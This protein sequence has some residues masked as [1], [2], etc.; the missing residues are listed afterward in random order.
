MTSAKQHWN[1]QKPDW[2]TFIW[3]AEKLKD[4]E[5]RFLQRAGLFQGALRHMGED[6]K[7][8]LTIEVIS[9]EAYKT[10]EIEG[11]FLDR[12]SLQSSL[13]RNFGLGGEDRR[14]PP[15][16]KGIAD[17]MTAL[18]RG[19]DRLLDGATLFHWHRLVMSARR[20]VTDVGCYRT[21]PDPMQVVSGAYGDTKV[22]FE[23]PPS[24]CMAAEMARFID[25]F[26]DT[27]PNNVHVLPPLT[28]A[29]IAHLWFV[30]IHPF[31][32]GNGRIGRAISEL[33]LSQALARPTL[34]ALAYAIE[35][36]RTAYY[37]ALE[38]SN[39]PLEITD[40]LLWFA[41]TVLA[42]QARSQNLIDFTI[43]KTKLLDRLRA[44]LNER[45]TKTL[46]RMFREG[47]DGFAGG[48]SAENYISVTGTSRATATRDLNDLVGMGALTRSG[49][50]KG[51]RYH[52]NIRTK[53]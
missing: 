35:T 30:S 51:T 46:L 22:H 52:L 26:N 2:P 29:G 48:L 40:W 45:Q 41:D 24:A 34:I 11:E 6:D 38:E 5:A 25:W 28:R 12:E 42:A 21:H 19:F 44:R 13:R 4:L 32:D 39:K 49:K 23:A 27:A 18:Y 15:A 8:A 7:T 9:A 36:R 16:E 1:W 31:E 3:D 37:R 33:A 10:S 17:M 47:P 43:E 14:I 50:L 53:E 20:D